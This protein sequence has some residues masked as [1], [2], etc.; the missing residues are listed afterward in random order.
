[1]SHYSI[2]IQIH[3]PH[4]IADKEWLVQI[5]TRALETEG[6]SSAS[7]GV[8]VTDDQTVRKLN[9]DYAG[10]DEVTDV[11]SFSQ[12]EGE[13][14]LTAPEASM[15]LGDVIISY[16]AAERQAKARGYPIEREL[17]HLLTHGIL[18]LLGYNHTK[19]QEEQQMRRREEVVVADLDCTSHD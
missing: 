18:H 13:P 9:H 19:P 16:P 6:T 11:L 2:D 15:E 4:A 12:T 14:F 3:D 10:L 5:A 1:M 17:A 8:V 7:L